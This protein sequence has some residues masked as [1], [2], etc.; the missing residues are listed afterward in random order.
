MA[1]KKAI[2]WFKVQTGLI[3]APIWQDI[4]LEY[5]SHGMGVGLLIVSFLA[6]NE[7]FKCNVEKLSSYCRR[8]VTDDAEMLSFILHKSGLFTTSRSGFTSSEWLDESVKQYVTRSE[9][10]K[11]SADNKTQLPTQLPGQLPTQLPNTEERSK[12]KEEDTTSVVVQGSNDKSTI[13]IVK[14]STDYKPSKKIL[15]SQ[16]E[17]FWI[18]GEKFNSI[19][20]EKLHT[21]INKQIHNFVQMQTWLTPEIVYDAFNKFFIE[22]SGSYKQNWAGLNSH[23]ARYCKN[24]KKSEYINFKAPEKSKLWHSVNSFI[25]QIKLDP[26][27]ASELPF[28]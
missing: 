16:T 14:D 8:F 1:S 28:D 4:Y 20:D 9:G 21:W 23:F 6:E 27:A 18:N 10:A 7:G 12:K 19:E 3:H 11:Q 5:G 22:N 25:Q 24:L 15:K 13:T 26:N 2:P 17:G